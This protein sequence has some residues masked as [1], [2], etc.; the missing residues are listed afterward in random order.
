MYFLIKDGITIDTI[1]LRK[2]KN[3]DFPKSFSTCMDCN[4]YYVEFRYCANNKEFSCNYRF[5][6]SQPPLGYPNE[7]P[8]LKKIMDWLYFYELVKLCLPPD[9][10]INKNHF[11]EEYLKWVVDWSKGKN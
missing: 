6:D 1:N 10:E 7:T 5:D 4:G 2:K 8:C 3:T 11:T 9:H